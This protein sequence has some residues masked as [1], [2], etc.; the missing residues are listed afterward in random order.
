MRRTLL[1]IAMTAVLASGAHA[2]PATCAIPV[3]IE[4]G[5]ITMQRDAYT[6]AYPSPGLQFPT[7]FG[8]SGWLDWDPGP[9]DGT[10]DGTGQ[11]VFPEFH[12]RFFTDFATPGTASL[13][14]NINATFTT[15]IQAR[16]VSGR[17]FLFA[18]EPLKADGTMRLVGTDFIN[19]QIA[20]QT[21]AGMTCRLTPAPDLASLPRGPS[22]AAVK[23]KVKAGPDANAPDDALTL[24]AV[25]VPG[26]TPP[27]LDGSADLLLRLKGASG[28]PLNLFV[29]G[30]R[31]AAK[32]KKKLILKDGDGSAIERIS[33]APSGQ[34]QPEP[35]PP[36]QG[37]SIVVT[38][39][40]KRTKLVFKV[41]GVDAA[42][43][44][45]A[46]DASVAVGTQTASRPVTFSAGK[47]GPKFK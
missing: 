45:G 27:V 28:A 33:D 34:D 37:G 13:A 30:G 11:V 14:G 6:T 12:M 39:G 23:G 1:S 17:S 20:L 42:Q 46:V 29:K 15:G 38:K 10:V 7:G 32:G 2:A 25:L 43:F 8:P 41:K 47:K 44:D 9:V 4:G 5:R 40:K 3:D 36:T 22:L 19:F 21:G 16:S 31:M 24:T 18:G 26:E 35:P